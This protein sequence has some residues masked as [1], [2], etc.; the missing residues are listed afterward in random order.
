MRSYP[1]IKVEFIFTCGRD[2]DIFVLYNNWASHEVFK[3]LSNH[4]FITMTQLQF[5]LIWAV[6]SRQ[7]LLR[8]APLSLPSL[9][10][11][12]CWILFAIKFFRWACKCA[13]LW[14]FCHTWSHTMYWMK[15]YDGLMGQFLQVIKL[16]SKNI[17]G[18]SGSL[19]PLDELTQ[20]SNVP[21]PCPDNQPILPN[22]HLQK[23][24]QA[25]EK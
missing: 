20:I 3:P 12:K 18:D 24:N 6:I 8:G 16:K 25:E 19:L 22:S 11:S 5:S 15:W 13:F 9:E 21:L 4:P 7:T 10:T 2:S 1:R 23:Q 14:L 17:Q